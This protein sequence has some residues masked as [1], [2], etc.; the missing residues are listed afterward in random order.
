MFLDNYTKLMEYF[1]PKLARTEVKQDGEQTV[2]V[3]W[4]RKDE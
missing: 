3:V 2:N 1:K 4:K